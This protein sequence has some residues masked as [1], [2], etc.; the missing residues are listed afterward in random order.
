MSSSN[1]DFQGVIG[2]T[3]KESVPDRSNRT[4]TPGKDAPNVVFI[5]LDDVGF[6]DLGCYGSEISTP[7]IDAMADNGLRFSNFHVTSMCSPTRACLLSGRNAHSAGV[8]IIAEWAS[9]FPGYQGKI[10][11]R[12][13]ILPEILNAHGYGSYAQ[14]KWHL[15]NIADYSAAGPHHDWPLG[16]GFARWYGFHG[17]LMDQWNPELYEDNHML[18]TVPPEGYHVSGDLVD[19]A[20]GHIRDH[21]TSAPERP[22]FTY[23]AFGACHW[24]HHVPAQ[25]MERYAGKYDAGWDEIRRRRLARQQALGMV[26]R[27]VELAPRNPDVEPWEQ[28]P[29][30]KQALTAKLQETYAAFLEHTDHEIGRFI[31]YLRAIGQLDNT[32]LVLLSD[33]GA[34]AEGG[35]TGAISM[36][37]HY[38]HE[39]ETVEKSVLKTDRLGSEHAYSHY[40]MGWAQVSNTPLKWYKKDT[41]GGGVRAPLIIQWNKGIRAKG[42]I[43][44]QFHHVIDI[45]PTILECLGVEAPAICQGVDQIPL[46]GISMKY[47]FEDGQ[48][49]TRRTTQY[50]ELLG[51]RAIWHKGWKAVARHAKG[52]D[53]SMDKW[54]LYH[55]DRD[56][57]ETR[58]LSGSEPDRLKALL[59]LWWREAEKYDVLPLDDREAE[60]AQDFIRQNARNHYEFLP[61]MARVDRLLMPE[62]SNRD[63]TIRVQL[64]SVPDN[65]EGTLIAW[66]SRFAGFV[67]YAKAG[68]LVYEYIYTDEESYRLEAPLPASTR[69]AGLRFTRTGDKRGTIE[70][71]VDGVAAATVQLEK[72]W[73]NYSLTAGLTC[74]YSGVPV[75]E[76]YRLPFRFTGKIGRIEID[77]SDS[78]DDTRA[79]ALR[80]ILAEE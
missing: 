72:T 4:G 47:V 21:I 43:R 76:Q 68:N 78:G 46:H 33:N 34:S 40:S 29:P 62:L 11:R 30:A 58:D 16:R 6:S 70:L 38:T 35:P 56:F 51:D 50:F 53:F 37:T 24:P 7:N 52:A 74:G 41:H 45:V 5:V 63:Y 20:M 12:A 26:D 3:Y 13:A 48:A 9:G 2:K 17:A 60:R 61:D 66:G 67:L 71:L 55:L 25:Y 65:A 1:P 19:Q 36:R 69:Q 59:D 22:F 18:K 57:N 64:D 14:G 44:G 75:S 77:L 31:D 54:E 39:P 42:Q 73:W 10:T 23:L 8:G 28:A 80:T 79:D 27:G 32:I 49:A 15:T